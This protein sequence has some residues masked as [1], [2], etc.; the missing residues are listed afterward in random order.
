MCVCVCVR[1]CARACIVSLGFLTFLFYLTYSALNRHDV[2]SV[3][4]NF[5]FYVDEHV[6]LTF[7]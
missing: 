5:N 7:V 4:L 1:V 2:V 3:Y 6:I